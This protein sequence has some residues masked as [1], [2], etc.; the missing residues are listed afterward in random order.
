M[1]YIRVISATCDDIL[2]EV[3]QTEFNNVVL[4]SVR[5]QEQLEDLLKKDSNFDVIL[6]REDFPLNCHPM[7]LMKSLKETYPHIR[8]VFIMVSQNE[9]QISQYTTFLNSKQIFDIIHDEDFGREELITALFEPKSVQDA[10][11]QTKKMSFE[12]EYNNLN[13]MNEKAANNF[14][15]DSKQYAESNIKMNYNNSISY[16]YPSPKVVAFWSPKGGSGVDTLAISTAYMLAQNTDI[17]VCIADFSDNPNMHLHLNLTDVQRN[18]ESLYIEQATGKLNPYTVENFVINGAT[19]FGLPNLHIIPGAFRKINFYKRMVE[20][21]GYKFVNDCLEKIIGTL[22]EKYTVVILILSSDIS[23]VTTY[24]ALHACSQIN[25]VLQN[26]ISGFFNANRYLDSKYGIFKAFK[27]DKSKIKLILNKDYV[28]D[29]F[30]VD[31]FVKMNGIPVSAKVPLLPDEC[32]KACKV[33]N[34]SELVNSDD[35]FFSI[36]SVVNTITK[37]E[38]QKETK[39]EE[40][41]G[42]FSSIL[43]KVKK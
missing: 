37:M 39:E 31:N 5:Y 2:E 6:F 17:N 1:N 16:S 32:F 14:E 8:I 11:M 18:L 36:L 21:D 26:D 22:K 40:K 25:M 34:P 15:E 27:I 35:A 4:Q 42:L 30:F 13:M 41:T 24:S 10:F 33:A 23:N 43:S 20:G 38:M 28:E 7:N 29:T 19:A 3:I 12:E 9:M